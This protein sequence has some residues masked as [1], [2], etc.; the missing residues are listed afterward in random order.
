MGAD[1]VGVQPRVGLTRS[2]LKEIGGSKSD[3]FNFRILKA[4][5]N[6][7]REVNWTSD[8]DKLQQVSAIMQALRGF[9]PMNVV[10]GMMAAQA[11]AQHLAGMDCFRTAAIAERRRARRGTP[12]SSR[13]D[14]P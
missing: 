12:R 14:T 1:T 8:S 10:E 7:R 6:V 9:A 13:T 4:A 2:G 11:V 3:R 5:L